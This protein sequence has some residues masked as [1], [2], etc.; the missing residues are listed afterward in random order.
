MS[1]EYSEDGLIEA[2]TQ[3]VLEQL[4]WTVLTAWTNENFGAV[5]LLGRENK[6]EVILRRYLLKALQKLN[7]ELPETA[8]QQAIEVIEQ[9]SS[10]KSLGRINKDKYK[11]FKEG[12]EVSYN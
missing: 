4:G 7:P 1:Y 8:Y 6:S 2:A 3:D 11:L 12:V 9:K 5:G 10:D